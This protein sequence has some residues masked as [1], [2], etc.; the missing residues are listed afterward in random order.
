MS[1]PV[2]P[3]KTILSPKKDYSSWFGYDYNMNLYRGCNHGCIYCDS[4]S[5]CYGITSF[6]TVCVK[7]NA[8]LLLE[9][10][11]ISK[12]KRGIVGSGAMSDPYNPFE[13]ELNLTANAL[14]LLYRYHYGVALFTKSPLVTRDLALL[15][16][17]NHQQPVLCA[18]TV[19]TAEDSLSKVLE[20][21][22][23]SSSL[24]L[25]AI[26]DLSKAGI[27]AGV[28]LTPVLPFL[29]DTSDQIEALVELS[30][31]HGAAFIYT[32]LG[33]T[34]RDIQR[35]YYYHHLDLHFPG[36]KKKYI[37][38][39]GSNYFCAARNQNHLWEVFASACEKRKI[40]YTMEEI[41]YGYQ[42]NKGTVQLSFF[43]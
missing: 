30:Y 37:S 17:I 9:K 40:P 12:R 39:F 10:E 38:T 25:K 6:D 5:Q 35:N 29:T 32:F 8:L 19:T 1:I 26:Q 24:R 28:L 7:E 11:L 15:S 43:K 21:H 31:Q 2:F 27:Y 41:I 18:I 33:M 34:L 36:L 4:R 42:K 14:A 16:K 3:A 20:P 22:A 13:K 23:P